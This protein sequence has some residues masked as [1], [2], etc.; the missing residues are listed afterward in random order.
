MVFPCFD[1][2]SFKCTFNL[3]VHV[4]DPNHTCISNTPVTQIIDK[5]VNERWFCFE[6]TPLMSTYLFHFTV[7]KFEYLET[8]SNKG[9]PIRVYTPPG[10]LEQGRIA[11]NVAKLSLEY[12]EDFYGIDYPLKKLD[13]ISLHTMHVRAMENW[14][15][16]T[17]NSMVLLMD[18]ET[19]SVSLIERNSRTVAH[20]IAHMWFGNLVTMDWWSDIWLNEGFARFCEFECLHSLYP[21]ANYGDFFIRDV[22]SSAIKADSKHSTHPIEME[23]P[24]PEK[25]EEIFDTISYAKGSS[26]IRMV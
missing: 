11:L 21:K 23:I 26:F 2:P 5:G 24:D 18:P 15:C 7:G 17:F 20:E 9:L 8:F 13:L 3:K 1:E 4:M 10:R 12:Y 25:L 16:I 22:F 19:T 14:G 6:E